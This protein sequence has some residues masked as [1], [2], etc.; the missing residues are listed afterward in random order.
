MIE[1]WWARWK[2]WNRKLKEQEK[3]LC[4]HGRVVCGPM[5]GADACEG[6]T[7][8]RGDENLQ[9]WKAWEEAFDRESL[10]LLRQR[11]HELSQPIHKRPAP[12]ATMKALGEIR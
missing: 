11:S 1:R 12:A 10:A 4:P 8:R 6:H 5:I 3:F 9:A 7:G 2:R